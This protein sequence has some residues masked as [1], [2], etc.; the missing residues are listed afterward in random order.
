MVIAFVFLSLE[1]LFYSFI[2]HVYF[3]D[4]DD[5]DVIFYLLHTVISYGDVNTVIIMSIANN[6]NNNNVHQSTLLHI[7]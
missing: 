4:L 3:L 7:Y 6:N 1:I 5:L 2:V